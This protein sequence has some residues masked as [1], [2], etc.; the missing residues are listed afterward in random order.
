MYFTEEMV[1]TIYDLETLESYLKN[2]ITH[3]YLFKF[4]QMVKN[5]VTWYYREKALIFEPIS[6]HL[7]PFLSSYVKT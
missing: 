7:E 2:K 4:D 1:A 5:Q 3:F 6:K